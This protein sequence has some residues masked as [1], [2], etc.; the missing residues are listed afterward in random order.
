MISESC[1]AEVNDQM[2]K[3][4]INNNISERKPTSLFFQTDPI[5]CKTPLYHITLQF[6]K[7]VILQGSFQI[8]HFLAVHFNWPIHTRSGHCQ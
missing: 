1:S 8:L 2:N 6:R 3:S 7:K 4:S 5:P